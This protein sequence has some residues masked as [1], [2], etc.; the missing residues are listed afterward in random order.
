MSL[1]D[2]KYVFVFVPCCSLKTHFA[3]KRLGKHLV[4]V[5]T[6]LDKLN[7]L[8]NLK[9]QQSTKLTER[10]KP[11][12]HTVTSADKRG[13]ENNTRLKHVINLICQMLS[14]IYIKGISNICIGHGKQLHDLK[15]IH[16]LVFMDIAFS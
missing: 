1:L 3:Q 16:Y 13:I 15:S 8:K 9:R 2:N 10:K 5:T 12:R 11:G 7:L 6:I 4:E 14:N